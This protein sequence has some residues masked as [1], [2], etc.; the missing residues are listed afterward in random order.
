MFFGCKDF[1]V[2]GSDCVL[3]HFDGD[4]GSAE[5]LWER[6]RRAKLAAAQPTPKK[7]SVAE[8]LALKA[9]LG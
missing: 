2:S 8:K 4:L 7:E 5:S 3:L 6:D 1:E 9:D